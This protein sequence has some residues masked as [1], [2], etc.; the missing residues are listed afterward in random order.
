LEEKHT[1]K[2]VI[3]GEALPDLVNAII[4]SEEKDLPPIVEDTIKSLSI[5]EEQ[6]TRIVGDHSQT[7]VKFKIHGGRIVGAEVIVAATLSEH[8]RKQARRLLG[9][10]L[11]HIRTRTGYGEITIVAQDGEVAQLQA[12]VSHQLT[13]E[14]FKN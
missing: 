9:V 13:N 5:I 7:A 6:A 2:K 8:L 11:D 14:H 1:L 10:V 12:Q 3:T 4:N